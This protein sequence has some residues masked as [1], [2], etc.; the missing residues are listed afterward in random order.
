MSNTPVQEPTAQSLSTGSGQT[1]PSRPLQPNSD[2]S[3]S[4]RV[5]FYKSGDY[6]FSGHRLVI[7]ARTFKSFDALLDALSKKVPLPFGVRTITT[8]RGTHLV[9]TLEDLHDGGSYV[10]SDQKRVKPLNLDEVKRRQVPWNTTRPLSAGRWR[11]Q[12]GLQSGRRNDVHNRGAR[13]TERVAVRTPKKLVVIRNKDPTVRRTIVLHRRIAPTFDALLDYLSQILQFPVLK[14]YSTDG[15]RVDGLAALILCSGVVVAAGNE[16]FRLGNY[17]FHRTGQTAQIM[18][19]ETVEPST[20]QPR[21]QN[22][23]SLSSGRGSRNFSLS[24]ERYIVNQINKSLN[25]SMNSHVRQ[26]N[27]SFEGEAHPHHTTIETREYGRVD[28][29]QHSIIVP[30]DDDIEKSFRVNQDGSMT[31]EMKVRLTIK[32]E[33]MLHWTTTLSRSSLRKG[34]VCASIS[35]SGNSSPNSNNAV[36]KDS[37]S[38][39]EDET[40]QENHS[41]G[42]GKAV[43]FNDGVYEGRTSAALGKGQTSFKRTPTPGPRYVKKK[44]SVES[45]KMVTES[46]VHE[47]T[48]GHYSFIE[49][50]ADGE[51]SEGYCVITHKS[52]SNR[53]VPKPR[54][55]A[56]A[57]ASNRGSRS[58]IRS[59]GAAEVLQIES[60]GMEVTET[61][62]HI[63]E[64]QGCYDNYVANEEYSTDGAALHDSPAVKDSKPSTVSGPRSSSN[65]IDFS[66]KPPTADSLQRQKEDMLSLSSDPVCSAHK[67][68]NDL[69]SVAENEPLTA[70]DSQIEKTVENDKTPKNKKD[71]KIIKPARKQK[72]STSSSDK[73]QK[74]SISPSKNSSNASVGKKSQ[75]SPESAN[76]KAEKKPDKPQS[77]KSIKDEKTPKKDSALLTSTENVKRTPPKRQST[78]KVAAKDNGHNINTPSGRPQMKKNMSDILKPKT[79]LLPVKSTVRKPKSMSEMRTLPPNQTPEINES[80]SMPLLNPTPSE[81]H[82]YVENW[83]EKVSP[84][85]V[86]YTEETFPNEPEPQTKVVFQIG[87]ESEPEGNNGSQTNVNEHDSQ[88]SDA[89]KKSISC[90]SVPLCHEAPASLMLHSEQKSRGL[91][92][93]M[94]SVRIDPG[95]HDNR[96]RA[97]KS[98]EDLGPADNESTSF[99]ILSPKAKIRPVLRQLCSSIQCIRRVSDTNA[100]SNLE[101]SNSLPDFST[102]V[103]L[104]FG[105]SCK[106]FLSFLSVM[107]LRDSLMGSAQGDEHQ[108]RSTSEAMLMMESL[109]KISALEDEEV[110][111]AS[112]TDLQSRASSQFRER[113]RDFMIFRERLESEPL[114]PRVSETEFALDVVS[115]GGDAFEDQNVR[116]NALMDELNLPE[117]LRAEISS[118]IHHAR[119]FYPVEESTFVETEKNLSDSEEEVEKFVEECNEEREESS[120]PL[121]TCLVGDITEKT[122]GNSDGET[123]SN[124]MQNI[125]CEQ[126]NESEQAGP[127][128]KDSEDSQIEIDEPLNQNEAEE[129]DQVVEQRGE[130]NEG[131]IEINNAEGEELEQ[132][133]REE[134]TEEVDVKEQDQRESGEESVEKVQDEISVDGEEEKKETLEGEGTEQRMSDAEEQEIEHNNSVEE[135]DDRKIDEETEDEGEK[136]E[137][138]RYEVEKTEEQAGD[139][140]ETGI[141]GKDTEEQEEVERDEEEDVQLVE[142]YV[143]EQREEDLKETTEH[144]ENIEENEEEI[145]ETEEDEGEGRGVERS[146]EEE[147]VEEAVSEEV[148]EKTEKEEEGK[149]SHTEERS[150]EEGVREEAAEETDE[151]EEDERSTHTNETSEMEDVE[152]VVSEKVAEDTDEE[153]EELNTTDEVEGRGEVDEGNSEGEVDETEKVAEETDE[154]QEVK[155]KREE[156]DE[157]EEREEMLVVNEERDVEEDE[158]ELDSEENNSEKD[159]EEKEREQEESYMDKD[160]D[161]DEEEDEDENEEEDED[162]NED[163]YEDMNEDKDEDTEDNVENTEMQITEREEDEGESDRDAEEEQTCD[164]VQEISK[165]LEKKENKMEDE[166]ADEREDV[167]ELETGGQMLEQK[168]EDHEDSEL[169]EGSEQT[170]KEEPKAEDGDSFPGDKD[171]EGL[172]DT[173]S[174]NQLSSICEGGNIEQNSESSTKYS[175]DIQ[176]E[177]EKGNGTDT[178]N[179]TDEGGEDRRQSRPHPVEISQ[180]LLDFV[181]S[182]LQSSSLTFSYDSRGNIRIEPD[183]ARVVATEQVVIPKSSSDSSYGVNCLPS[184]ST[185]DLSDYRPE[186]SESGGYKTQESVDVVTESGEDAS[187]KPFPIYRRKSDFPKRPREPPR[188]KLSAASEPHVSEG[189]GLKSAGTSHGSGSKA[190]RE[191][192]SYFSAASSL[193]ADAEAAPGMSSEKDSADGVLIDQGRWL[194][195]ENHLIRKS[196]PVSLGMYDNLDSTSIDT[197]QENASEGSPNHG[198]SQQNPLAAI[199]SSELEEMAKPLTPKCTYYNMPHGS[200][201]DP[202]LDEYSISGKKDTSSFKGR[203]SKVTPIDTSKTRVNKNGSLSSFASVEFKIPDKKVHPEG[204]SVAVAQTRR[205]SSGGGSVLQAQ[206]SLDTLHLRCSQYCPI[207]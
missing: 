42:A 98:A 19:V 26:P 29:E 195:K 92:A 43:G 150:E 169:S 5:C 125:Y 178:V 138:G 173:V 198:K 49:R 33:E 182:A 8:P 18:Y 83:L 147:G 47:N 59:S 95:L 170:E 94:P 162:E 105:S 183:N 96:L 86:P 67:I 171:C 111:K 129:E 52:N 24:S 136:K 131:S 65:D 14:L 58:S 157:E 177:D 118:T 74:T 36:A 107:T 187:D 20:L 68:M 63:Y 15:R 127:D 160:V 22:N 148:A 132:I 155:N 73:K 207:L 89:V 25:G 91:C 61:V 190:S 17:S 142:K 205:T 1:L 140:E 85:Q 146:E 6:K 21:A 113:W 2:P 87:G 154:E 126:V 172:R 112:L 203:G 163:K 120:E 137:E 41:G 156:G 197:G 35:E 13:V 175:S 81:I 161:E 164:Y 135:S 60:N 144:A 80:V 103:A 62:M 189:A 9:K 10:C 66:W 116:I 97:H 196:P 44:A 72:S 27:G 93:S 32:E 37:S 84:D 108:S 114:S 199:S 30:H 185:S 70:T 174:L 51:S 12:Q 206:D 204:A 88:P 46:G 7:N 184:P 3:A 109:Q 192:L 16:P 191:D 78:N 180:Q 82:Q 166:S 100:T 76:S 79:N 119:S 57:G 133:K 186:S 75:S 152:E 28:T 179:E 122:Q 34:T 159:E 64:S 153:K 123:E 11:R 4:K 121:R 69:S 167:Y 38:I 53:P 45:V 48:T 193:K 124:T 128:V 102:Q 200:D 54:K 181:N 56:S 104:V 194:L 55:T 149:T 202:F 151:D 101:K 77:K 99:N 40:K 143:K 141:T 168:R 115:E 201:S 117:D 23:K 176:C 158:L 50:T 165:A 139:V 145:E 106:A 130:E 39:S 31:V 134:E 110:Q 90:L 188:S 71:K